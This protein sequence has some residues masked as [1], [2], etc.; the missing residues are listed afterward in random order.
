MA[1]VVTT[2]DC[3]ASSHLKLNIDRSGALQV[4]AFTEEELLAVDSLW[5][6]KIILGMW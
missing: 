3:A 1:A 2:Q 4:T 5:R 6:Q